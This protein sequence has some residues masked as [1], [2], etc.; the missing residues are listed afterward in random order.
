MPFT[1]VPP[2]TDMALFNSP[3]LHT[4][5]L[6]VPI[7][8]TG[9]IFTYMATGVPAMSHAPLKRKIVADDFMTRTSTLQVAIAKATMVRSLERSVMPGWSV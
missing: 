2:T 7:L 4:P 3:A 6:K 1:L 5:L 9:G 8:I